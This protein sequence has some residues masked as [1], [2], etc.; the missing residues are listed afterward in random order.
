[1]AS[2][3]AS[4]HAPA[5]N[6]APGA[7]LAA[8]DRVREPAFIGRDTELAA[9]QRTLEWAEASWGDVVLVEALSGGGKTRLLDE[10]ARLSAGRGFW[11]LRGRGNGGEAQRPFQLLDEVVREVR[12]EARR[13][14]KL[15]E[16]LR[17]RLGDEREAVCA[18]LPVLAEVLGQVDTAHLGPEAHGVARTLRALAELLDAL[19][20]AEQP[21]VLLLDDCQWAGE[22]ALQLFGS[23]RKRRQ[24]R[25]APCHTLLVLAF[26]SEEGG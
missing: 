24:E 5:G 15:A 18:A 14:P 16:G 6:D 22:L 21:A 25:T 3:P 26:R 10:M 8:G 19:G 7:P 17:A 2:D 23:W 9:F 20:T 13:D 1:M 11:V 12:A 4:W